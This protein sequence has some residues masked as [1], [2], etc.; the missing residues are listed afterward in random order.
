MGE[1]VM[2]DKLELDWD[3]VG[4][5]SER[6]KDVNRADADFQ[7]KYSAWVVLQ[8]RIRALDPALW[9]EMQEAKRARNDAYDL[10]RILR[11]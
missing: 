8:N 10:L 2:M 6:E 4:P 9:A 5:Q 11:G 1:T 7:M 3:E